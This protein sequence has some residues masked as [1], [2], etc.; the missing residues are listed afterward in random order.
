MSK[1]LL[2]EKI[3]TCRQELVALSYHH[4]LTSQ[5]VI[6][7]SMK[8]DTLINKYQNYDNYELASR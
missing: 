1:A 5:A 4:E 7:S 8:L 6:E 3:E 2:L